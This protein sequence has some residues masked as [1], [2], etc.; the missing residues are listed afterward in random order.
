MAQNLVTAG[1]ALATAINAFVTAAMSAPAA[2]GPPPVARAAHGEVLTEAGTALLYAQVIAAG[3]DQV[4]RQDI[5][6]NTWTNLTGLAAEYALMMPEDDNG[7]AASGLESIYAIRHGSIRNGL[8][9]VVR[10]ELP[11]M[12]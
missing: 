3:D 1:Q 10:Q 5:I 6:F 12:K 2:G 11:G 4:L 8:K 7:A 9:N